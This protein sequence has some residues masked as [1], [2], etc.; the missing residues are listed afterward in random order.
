MGNGMRSNVAPLSLRFIGA[1]C[2]HLT[3]HLR[4]APHSVRH[5]ALRAQ[6][7]LS[8]QLRLNVKRPEWQLPRQSGF[9]GADAVAD[10]NRYAKCRFFVELENQ[11]GQK[12]KTKTGGPTTLWRQILN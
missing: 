5:L 8:R 3:P 9:A 1:R 2:H 10:A 12:Q 4:C 7:P 6:H 11:W